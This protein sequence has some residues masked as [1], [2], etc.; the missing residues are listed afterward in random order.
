MRTRLHFAA[1]RVVAA[2]IAESQRKAVN[3]IRR[4]LVG[5]LGLQ[6]NY[7]LDRIHVDADATIDVGLQEEVSEILRAQGPGG[8][9]LFAGAPE[10]TS[11]QIK[12]A[13]RR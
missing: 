12:W 13:P 10:L 5:K 4:N 7:D 3:L 6:G 11:H 1:S 9:V 8:E 2:P